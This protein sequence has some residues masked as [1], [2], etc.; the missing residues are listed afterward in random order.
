MTVALIDSGLGS[1]PTAARLRRARP[2]LDLQLHLDPDGAPWG[3]KPVD[4]TVRRVVD[5]ARRAVDGGAAVVVLPCNT[6]S[7]VALAE[8]RAALGPSVP[9]VGTVPA[10]KPAARDCRTIAVWATA[11]TTA[12]PY[13]AALIQQFA[14]GADVAAV[15]C[16]GLAD[17]I[18]RGD[19]DAV[20]AAIVSAARRTPADTEAIVLGCTH[21]P[22][23]EAEILASLAPTVR[24]YDSAD[25]VA[26]QTLRQVDAVG[27]VPGSGGL[28]VFL[29]G[30][31]GSLPAQALSFDAGRELA[32]AA[33]VDRVSTDRT[34][35]R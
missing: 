5:T 12:S 31:P 22:L 13:Q 3:P 34:V 26:A 8:T 29:S 18:D 28:S 4:W 23:V 9:V 11:A 1:L 35:L 24:M 10:I 7:V 14:A 27:A 30:R 32:A 6:A 17:A 21:Y 33:G 25:A 15:A 16:H 19:T 20:S 2:D